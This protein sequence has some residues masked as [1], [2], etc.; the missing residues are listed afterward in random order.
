MTE[1]YSEQVFRRFVEDLNSSKP[2]PGGGSAA[3]FTGAMARALA[4]MTAHMTVGKKSYAAVEEDR[5][6]SILVEAP[7]EPDSALVQRPLFVCFAAL[8]CLALLILATGCTCSLRGSA[9][10]PTA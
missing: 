8:A 10:M 5:C 2:A 3:A 4:G 1:P 6:L 7:Y 9:T